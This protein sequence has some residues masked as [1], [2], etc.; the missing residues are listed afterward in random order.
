[1]WIRMVMLARMIMLSRP[2]KRN[3]TGLAAEFVV[4]GDLK[5]VTVFGLG[6]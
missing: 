1:M 3:G 5:C 6:F 2:V 4:A